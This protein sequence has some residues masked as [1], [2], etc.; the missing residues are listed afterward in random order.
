MVPDDTLEQPN[1][2][3]LKPW[4]FRLKTHKV[5]ILYKLTNTKQD[6][7]SWPFVSD[8]MIF[9]CHSFSFCPMS[10]SKEYEGNGC[11]SLIETSELDVKAR[12]FFW[13]ENP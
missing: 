8:G 9:N 4:S 1:Y 12:Y 5:H 3:S 10:C 7:W 2:P 6:P 11:G 13:E